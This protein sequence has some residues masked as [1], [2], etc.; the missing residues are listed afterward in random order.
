MRVFHQNEIIEPLLTKYTGDNDLN[1]K[2]NRIVS[3][4]G[5]EFCDEEYLKYIKSHSI[6][7]Y[8]NFVL[9][10][11]IKNNDIFN[12]NDI[13]YKLPILFSSSIKFKNNTFL[14][15]DKN[16]NVSLLKNVDRKCIFEILLLN[17]NLCQISYRDGFDSYYLNYEA[18]TFV[19]SKKYD[20]TLNQLYYIKNDN[21]FY[22][23]K[24]I[25]NTKKVLSIVDGKLTCTTDSY[26]NNEIILNFYIQE[27]SFN[28]NSSWAS[29]QK[30]NKNALQINPEKSIL[31]CSNNILIYNNY[32]YIS[33][34]EIEA[35]FL[36]LKNHHTNKNYSYRADNLQNTELNIPNIKIREYNSVNT[37]LNQELG[38][39]SI[40]LTY[41][42]YNGD[43][44]FHKDSYTNFKIPHSTYP[45]EQLNI[46]DSL[47]FRN[48]AIAGNT[49]YHSDKLFF[50][51][52]R[53]NTETTRYLCTW[54]SGSTDNATWVDRYYY[55]EKCNFA[56]SLST[57]PEFTFYDEI[58]SYLN[59][60][61]AP[62][63]YYDNFIWQNNFLSELQNTP[64]KIRDAIWG[65][66]FF[67]KKSDVIL[68]SDQ[69]YIYQRI[70]EK[71]A[72]KILD[73]LS[74]SIISDGLTPFRRYDGF[75]FIFDE[76]SNNINYEFT[77]NEYSLIEDYR[78]IN[79]T[80]EFTL[81]FSIN[82]YNWPSG[83]GNQI[84]GSFNDRGFGIFSDEK[85]TP[86][87]MVQEGRMANIY[88]SSF[89]KIDSVYLAQDELDMV[90]LSTVIN[91]DN[92]KKV[93]K[94]DTT[95]HAIKDI[96]RTE[97]LNFFSP[98]VKSITATFTEEINAIIN[99]KECG[100]LYTDEKITSR[101]LSP[102]NVFAIDGTSMEKIQIEQCKFKTR[103]KSR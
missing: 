52:S 92:I 36:T 54:L 5:F 12:F 38:F 31:D 59:T 14:S 41:D 85:I 40:V 17:E 101:I 45:F 53:K 10:E 49:P 94:Y 46:N 58:E 86:F 21:K 91:N 61:L 37:G 72:Q 3:Q 65:E 99:R 63:A 62:S 24:K 90:A 42:L 76:A 28:G 77:G 78:K 73:A 4:D 15:I 60:V 84:M 71:Y 56:A 22:F 97:H 34:S 11:N 88:N 47:L 1:F 83:F 89:E 51:D 82:S 48:G 102:N 74:G 69:E 35:N 19:F 43:Y 98:T 30:Y 25:G 80:N 23:F 33:G 70:G 16:Y 100:I 9:T 79:D 7:N 18:N 29:Y 27:F 93:T 6:N 55:P 67:D 96:I 57:V 50:K 75:E 68:V 20:L 32:T 2:G 87:I 26:L 103:F 95:T 64:Q 81:S 8:S 44:T 13:K 39:D 66:Y